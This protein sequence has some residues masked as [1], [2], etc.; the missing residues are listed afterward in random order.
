MEYKILWVLFPLAF[1]AA[2]AAPDPAAVRAD[3][4]REIRSAMDAGKQELARELTL[5]CSQPGVVHEPTQGPIAPDSISAP[6]LHSQ[7]PNAVPD[8]SAAG[9][10]LSVD[11]R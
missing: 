4:D 7:D 3:C 10:G 5:D 1:A 11:G 8:D 6:S 2:C 9:P